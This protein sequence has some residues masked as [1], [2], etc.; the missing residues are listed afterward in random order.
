M[1]KKDGFTVEKVERKEKGMRIDQI[2][3]FFDKKGKVDAQYFH[4][5]GKCNYLLSWGFSKNTLGEKRK[6]GSSKQKKPFFS[7]E[8]GWFG[9]E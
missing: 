9:Y 5:N 2:T 6:I 8:H 4:F 1:S 3:T 7:L